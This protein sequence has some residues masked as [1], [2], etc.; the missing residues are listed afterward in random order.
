MKKVD[1][2]IFLNLYV[3]KNII[4]VEIG[5]RENFDVSIFGKNGR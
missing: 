2:I 3:L 1:R 4:L 5:G